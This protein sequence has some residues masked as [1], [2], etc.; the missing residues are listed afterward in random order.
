MYQE[1]RN[2]FFEVTREKV[3]TASGIEVPQEALINSETSDVLG[4]VSNSY[5]L[6][7]NKDVMDL[8]DEAIRDLAVE[9]T[10]DHMDSTTKRWKRQIV[11]SDGAL[12]YPITGSDIVGILLEISNGYTGRTSFGYRLMGYRALCSNGMVMGKK[13]LFQDSYGHYVDSPGRLRDSFE[14]KFEAFKENSLTWKEWSTTPFSR[15]D[16]VSFIDE[17]TKPES[18]DANRSQYLPQRVSRI[19]KDSYQPL[20]E[21]QSLPDTKWGAFNVLT[22]IY[23]HETKAHKGSNVFSSRYNTI[24]RLAGDFYNLK[25]PEELRMVVPA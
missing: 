5:E 4:I 24:E 14:L 3:F 20:L 12:K 7:T 18:G 9:K 17:H 23:T 25:R 19:I 6:V 13:D 22:W 8:F 10:I 1:N 11:F 2:P 16:F 15:D 21:R